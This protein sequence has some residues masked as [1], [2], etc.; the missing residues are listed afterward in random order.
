MAL[1]S[2]R[3]AS[4]IEILTLLHMCRPAGT[5][6]QL[7]DAPWIRGRHKTR[8]KTIITMGGARWPQLY[9]ELSQESRTCR[10]ARTVPSSVNTRTT[11][12]LS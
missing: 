7:L 9:S 6:Q 8:R 5:T 2:V 12:K 1:L 11:T 4:G 10:P 3:S